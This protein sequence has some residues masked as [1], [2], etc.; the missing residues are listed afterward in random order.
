[1]GFK[2]IDIQVH[3]GIPSIMV[4]DGNMNR[5]F[6]FDELLKF[7]RANRVKFEPLGCT[8]VNK[9]YNGS[10]VK[11]YILGN[12]ITRNLMELEGDMIKRL[13]SDNVLRPNNL[14]ITTDGRLI[15]FNHNAEENKQTAPQTQTKANNKQKIAVVNI[16]NSNNK[17]FAAIVQ[18]EAGEQKTVPINQIRKPR[19]DAHTGMLED[20]IRTRC[21]FYPMRCIC[22]GVKKN[23]MGNPEFYK[24]KNR[25]N[26]DTIL[27]RKMLEMLLIE[28]IIHPDNIKIREDNSHNLIIQVIG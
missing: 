28:G 2:I 12:F 23:G 19:I 11:A 27:P 7:Q 21:E 15:S 22:T 18:N 1:M 24:F 5:V 14:K 4:T 10:I 17:G 9:L 8:C 16:L 26:E 25:K 20:C 13:M 3:N 6:L